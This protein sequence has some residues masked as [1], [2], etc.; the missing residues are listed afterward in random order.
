MI[1]LIKRL[2]EK[3][4]NKKIVVDEYAYE[5]EVLGE[6]LAQLK[7]N[8][9]A[10]HGLLVGIRPERIKIEKVVAGK[11]Y[12]GVVKVKSTVVELLGGEYNIHFDIFDKDMVCKLDATEKVTTDDELAVSF[13][14]DDLYIFDL[15]TGD[16]I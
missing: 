5:K 9:T 1:A 8:A 13:S 3:Q 2:I 10:K 16:R 12:K 4:K 7:T 15:V 11:K 6:K 14:P